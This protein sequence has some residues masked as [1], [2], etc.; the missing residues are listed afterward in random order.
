MKAE[1]RI[2]CLRAGGVNVDEWMQE[3]EALSVQ[4]LPRSG[5]SLSVRTDASGMAVR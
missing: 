1:A 4:D 5:S 2:E 3:A